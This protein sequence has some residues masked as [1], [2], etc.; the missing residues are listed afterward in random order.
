[1]AAFAGREAGAGPVQVGP[2][3]TQPA[4]SFPSSRD[5]EPP[6][7][8]FSSGRAP[9]PW[10]EARAARPVKLPL[11]RGLAGSAPREGV[12]AAMPANFG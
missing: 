9:L 5:D 10:A 3:S 1:M 2:G 7:E 12:A 6:A 4:P 8:P 11:L